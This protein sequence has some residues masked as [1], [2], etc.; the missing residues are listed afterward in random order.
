VDVLLREAG[1]EDA[2]AA[3]RLLVDVFP[4]MPVSSRRIRHRMTTADPT[5]AVRHVAALD[6]DRLIGW[7][8]SLIDIRAGTT[9]QGHILV[10]VAPPWRNR[11]IGSALL[12]DAERHLSMLGVRAIRANALD[13][14]DI[15]RFCANRGWHPTAWTRYLSLDLFPLV[16]T[17]PPAVPNGVQ[18][19]PAWV[20]ED[21]RPL[22]EVHAEATMDEP[23]EDRPRDLSYLGWLEEVWH[24]TDHDPSSGTV[25][26]V[27]GKVVSFSLYTI[28]RSSARIWSTMTGTRRGYRGRGL[29]TLV[30]AV[31]LHRAAERGFR[32]A[33]AAG[34]ADNAPMAAVNQHLGYHLAATQ[35]TVIRHLDTAFPSWPVDLGP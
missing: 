32:T 28:D 26:V 29:A 9:G 15:R 27:G 7:S 14:D 30:K 8:R 5:E 34:D 18:V 3:A 23:R 22:Y 12:A 33:W 25:A 19:L 17:P 21:L 13:S 20:M 10:V 35:V 6:A 16:G 31:A 2:R 24:A 11:G 4:H 1:P